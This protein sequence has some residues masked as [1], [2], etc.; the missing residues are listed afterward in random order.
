MN[1]T[2]PQG[3]AARKPGQSARPG[4]RAPIGLIEPAANVAWEVGFSAENRCQFFRKML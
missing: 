4:E 1:P 2:L 3:I